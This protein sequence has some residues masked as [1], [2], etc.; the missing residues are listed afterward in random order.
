MDK[1]YS[2]ISRDKTFDEAIEI[3]KNRNERLVQIKSGRE[4]H[5]IVRIIPRFKSIWL[6]TKHIIGT[7]TFK[8][9]DGSDIVFGSKNIRLTS[10]INE[11]QALATSGSG[12]YIGQWFGFSVSSRK[13][14]I[15]EKTILEITTTPVMSATTD[16]IEQSNERTELIRLNDEIEERY[17]KL[18]R[19]M[20]EFKEMN[21]NKLHEQNNVISKLQCQTNDMATEL[22]FQKRQCNQL[23]SKYNSDAEKS[24]EEIERLHNQVRSNK[25]QNDLLFEQNKLFET[26][27]NR[28]EL[29]LSTNIV[30][31]SNKIHG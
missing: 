24:K 29:K 22:E 31:N 25:K 13:F 14:V 15:C 6:G 19:E 1:E 16:L 11:R 20:L 23:I 8:W 9:L 30:D 4:N 17:N 3:C 12:S 2:I 26:R 27:L 10:P 18:S 5:F 7:N 21:T 28:L